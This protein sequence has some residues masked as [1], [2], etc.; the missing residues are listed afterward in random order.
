MTIS[1]SLNAGVAGLSAN[2]TRLATIADNIAN[3]GTFG[4]KRSVAEFRS[5]VLGSPG[6]GSYVA[7]GVRA[8]TLRLIEERGPLISTG[9]ATDLAVDGRGFLPVT[10]LTALNAGERPFSLVG[11][12]SFRL[13]ANGILRT[14]AGQVLL[15][16]PVQADGTVGTV[17][18]DTVSALQPVTVA[19]GA[20]V[21]NPTTSIGLAVN[22]P[23]SETLSTA[24]GDP[25]AVS[26]EY[27]GNVGNAE[28]L[29]VTFTP[30][31]P[32]TGASNTWTMVITDSASNDAVVGEYTLV[33]D[34]SAA[35]GGTLAS[36][37]TVSGGVY[38]P[39]TGRIP[40]AVGGGTLSVR[41]GEIGDRTGMT[42]YDANFGTAQITKDGSAAAT[43]ATIEVDGNGFLS[44]V[45]DQGFS[46]RL[47]QIPVV[48]VPNPNGLAAIKDQAYRITS[49]S[50]PFF[51]W[52]AGAGPVGSI[53]AFSREESATDVAA[54]LTRLIQTQRA[55]SSNAK[56]IQTVDEML[57]ETTNIKR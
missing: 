22:L 51:L 11:T 52:D 53:A 7:G 38:D 10:D 43:L 37:T 47:F 40:L 27:F 4:Y 45:Y 33:F 54:E 8:S 6:A 30:T 19:R 23:W 5:M 17:P 36:V 15:G 24:S 18:R 42:Q 1:S 29:S 34:T 9:N 46:R 41:L 26:V 20:V 25:L 32:L 48:D 12:G 13:D 16:W 31:I 35:N 14:E 28:R 56:V 2:A 21:A 49:Q 55:Y 3:S 50:G 39:A 57:Q 44:A